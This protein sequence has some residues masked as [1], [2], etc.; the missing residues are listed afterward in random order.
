[1]TH[2][3]KKVYSNTYDKHLSWTDRMKA[4]ISRKVRGKTE[5]PVRGLEMD[6][7]TGYVT[8]K[9]PKDYWDTQLGKHEADIIGFH[10][11]GP[12]DMNKAL[13]AYHKEME[14]GTHPSQQ[15]ESNFKKG[16]KSCGYIELHVKDLDF[17]II[18]K[19]LIEDWTGKI[20]KIKAD[21]R[22]MYIITLYSMQHSRLI[23]T[24]D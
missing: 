17:A 22:G 14:A 16:I 6:K 4:K 23:K 20:A 15:I 24:Y 5:G 10:R 9:A 7:K 21:N 12:A 18:F 19:I 2:R 13:Q 1:M 3:E 8:H 11:T